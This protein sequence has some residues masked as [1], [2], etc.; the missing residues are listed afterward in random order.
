MKWLINLSTIKQ[1]TGKAVKSI[2]PTFLQEFF[3]LYQRLMKS[4]YYNKGISK[5]SEESKAKPFPD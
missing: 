3:D 5:H 1:V 2:N 4:K